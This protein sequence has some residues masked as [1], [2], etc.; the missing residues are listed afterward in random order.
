MR[1]VSLFAGCGGLDLGLIRAGHDVVYASDFD[2]DCVLTYKHNIGDHIH[3]EDVHDLNCQSLPEFD[4]L[5]GG[6]PCQGFSVANLYRSTEDTRN[7]L[8]TQIV[9]IL[10]E[11]R[12]R[13]FLAENVP[14]ILSLSKGAVVRIITQE[15]SEIGMDDGFPGYD[16][17]VFLLNAANYGVPQ[18]RKR[19]IFLGISREEQ[20][21]ARDL[22]FSNF[23]PPYTHS[24]NEDSQLLTLRTLSDVIG[25]LPEPGDENPELLPNHYGT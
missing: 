14:G 4:I 20:Q 25:D 2:K 15:F 16:V 23:P 5:T 11:T 19:V 17:K 21:L 9:R 13:Y 7:E 24:K 6:F 8:Y 22:F 18:N 3:L 12:P 10:N 1:V